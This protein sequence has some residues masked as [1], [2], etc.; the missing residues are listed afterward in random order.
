MLGRPVMMDPLFMNVCAGSWLIC[1]VHIDRTM[2]VSSTMPPMCGNKSQTSWPD[3]PNCLKPCVGPKQVSFCPW[4]W[5][6]CCPLV[7]DSGIGLP[8]MSASFGL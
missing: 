3:S 2:H 1:S 8:L 4:S 6:I 5:A 7:N